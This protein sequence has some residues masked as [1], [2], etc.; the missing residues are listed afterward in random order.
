MAQI[1]LAG[2]YAAIIDDEDADRVLA[3]RWYRAHRY[4]VHGRGGSN[5]TPGG[6]I[7][8]H[9]FVIGAQPGQI[10]DH[11]NGNGLDCRKSNLRAG[12][13]SLNNINR[14]YANSCGYRG[15]RRN[16]QSSF[17]VAITMKGERRQ[18]HGFSSA[19]D[20]ARAYDALAV[21]FHGSAAILNF[22]N[23]A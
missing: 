22:P 6:R 20:A 19:E 15:V 21:Q 2:G 17:S 16:H 14:R 23:E 12:D 9:R 5:P 8:L 3:L 4:A 10:V 1:E 7:Y 11:I 18:L 13:L